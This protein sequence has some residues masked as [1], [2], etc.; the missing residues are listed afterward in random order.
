MSDNNNRYHGD[1][2]LS[3]ECHSVLSILRCYLLK[4][5]TLGHMINN[6][7]RELTEMTRSAVRRVRSTRRKRPERT[8]TPPCEDPPHSL[9]LHPHPPTFLPPNADLS[10]CIGPMIRWHRAIPSYDPLAYLQVVFMINVFS[11]GLYC[12]FCHA[13][14]LHSMSFSERNNNQ[15]IRGSSRSER[16]RIHTCQT[17]CK[18]MM[19]LVRRKQ[20]RSRAH[21]L[22]VDQRYG[23]NDKSIH[24]YYTHTAVRRQWNI[25]YYIVFMFAGTSGSHRRVH[26]WRFLQCK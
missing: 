25:W 13:T 22:D 5:L 3:T 17:A 26:K 21:Q 7:R 16:A 10:S 20:T 11:W 4:T 14:C 8:Q 6:C 2:T 15:I 12:S 1:A 24:S 23:I 18:C 19:N 9:E